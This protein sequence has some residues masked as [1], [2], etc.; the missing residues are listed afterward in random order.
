MLTRLS[1]VAAAAT[2]LFVTGC[3]SIVRRSQPSIEQLAREYRHASEN[4]AR[5]DIA[6]KAIDCN[7][8]GQTAPIENVR[9]LFGTHFVESE[10]F[11]EDRMVRGV[12]YFDQ[13]EYEQVVQRHAGEVVQL[14][15]V[16]WYMVIVHRGGQIYDYELTNTHK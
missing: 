14:P 11:V 16:G 6:I 4:C 13:P 9:K 2:V 7:Y 10:G 5:R 1:V 8:I 3:T 12:V 15:H